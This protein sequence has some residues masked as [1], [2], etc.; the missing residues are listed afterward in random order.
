MSSMYLERSKKH[1]E[2]HGARSSVPEYM[3]LCVIFHDNL[4]A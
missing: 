4:Y 1:Q 2:A 3:S